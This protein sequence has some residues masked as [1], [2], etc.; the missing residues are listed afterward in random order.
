MTVTAERTRT[1]PTIRM[2]MSRRVRQGLLT[3]HIVLSVGLLGDSAGFLAVAIRAAGDPTDAGD[4]VETLQMFSAVFGIPL[5]FGAL[6]SGIALSLGT[7]WGVFRYP[8]VTI[9]LGLIASVILVGALIIGPNAETMRATGAD[10]TAWL[11]GAAAYDVAALTLATVLSV[12]K[13]GKRFRR[14]LTGSA[15]GGRPPA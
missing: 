15:E 10:T 7:K 8:W 2:P 13:P 5:S 11:I 3:A 9:K 14:R 12:F 6:L 4:L 1:A